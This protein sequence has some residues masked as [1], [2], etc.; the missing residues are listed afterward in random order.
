MPAAAPTMMVRLVAPAMALVASA[1]PPAASPEV[2]RPVAAPPGTAAI[3]APERRVD[4]GTRR[5][6]ATRN[7]DKTEPLVAVVTPI[8]VGQPAEQKATLVLA[9]PPAVPPVPAAPA[10]PPAPSYLAVGRLDPGPIPLH[11]IEPGYPEEAGL[12]RGTVVL[13]LL[14]NERGDVDDVAVVRAAPRGL[15]ESSALAAF[16][17]A[18]FSPGMLLGVPVKSQ[19]TIEVEFT[20]IN[21][22]STVSG[23]GY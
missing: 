8:R 10:L 21:R 23:R 1:S 13:R 3:E 6:A 17:S 12:Q 4:A 15:F 14:I 20:P 18:K 9:E 19:L 5:V 11:D 7:A 2:A 22:G 16:G